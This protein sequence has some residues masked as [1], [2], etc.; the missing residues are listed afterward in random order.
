MA[1]LVFVEREKEW[2]GYDA[3][4]LDVSAQGARIEAG[5][6]LT[7]GQAVEV[8]PINGSDPVAGRV[9]WVGKPASE[10]E[11]QAGLEFLDPFNVPT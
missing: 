2:E 11:G 3:F 8:V 5:V 4:T 10:L 7:P 9:V 1:I 6:S